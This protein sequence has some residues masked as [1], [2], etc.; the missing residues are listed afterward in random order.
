MEQKFLSL[1]LAFN[2]SCLL[3]K[4]SHSLP[5]ALTFASEYNSDS[6]EPSGKKYWIGP[7]RFSGNVTLSMWQFHVLR[8]TIPNISHT[9]CNNFQSLM[10]RK[11]VWQSHKLRHTKKHFLLCEGNQWNSG[12]QMQYITYVTMEI[13]E[14]VK[15]VESM[16][17]DRTS[18]TYIKRA[19]KLN[20]MSRNEMG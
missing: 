1:W 4:K 20:I 18:S 3:Q 14:W 17:V 11:T 9:S 7:I 8:P 13:G 15:H 12:W 19:D 10:G 2:F 6:T 16:K 5:L